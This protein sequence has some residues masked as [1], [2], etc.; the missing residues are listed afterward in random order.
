M[1]QWDISSLESDIKNHLAA[2]S[3]IKALA[4]KDGFD[5]NGYY[6]D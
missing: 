1:D 2:I 3:N 4:D 5:K 6:A